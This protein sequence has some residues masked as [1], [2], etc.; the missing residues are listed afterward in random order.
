MISLAH[1]RSSPNPA[2]LPATANF[3]SL[4]GL[5]TGFPNTNLCLFTLLRTLLHFFALPKNSSLLFSTI[6]ALFHKN[7][8]VCTPLPLEPSVTKSYNCHFPT[9]LVDRFHVRRLCIHHHRSLNQVNRDHY[10]EFPLPPQQ[11]PLHPR[12]RPA[13]QPHPPADCQ[14][15]VRFGSHAARQALFQPL[16]FFVRQR[17]QLSVEP[18]ETNNTW[19][20]QHTQAINRRHAHKY[21]TREE[22]HLQ[23]HPPIFAAPY[24][25]IDRK[26]RFDRPLFH[27]VAHPFFVIRTGVG[28]IPA[29]LQAN[30]RR[31]RLL[32]WAENLNL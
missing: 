14:E 12:Q 2:A 21:V 13:L 8:G 1:A 27:L 9:P 24:G 5:V 19:N 18:N 4:S 10:P 29:Q 3:L 22:R 17:R 25:L 20:L 15:R 26:K 30:C 32:S 7:T 23:L 31:K 11:D 6:S 16:D 28:G